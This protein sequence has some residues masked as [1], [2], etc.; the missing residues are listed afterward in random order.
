MDSSGKW[1]EPPIWMVAS[2]RSKT[3]GQV[4]C[5]AYLSKQ[6]YDNI[7]CE[8]R[9]W[10]DKFK[11]LLIYRVTSELIYDRDII[12]IHVDFH[13]KTRERICHYLKRSFRE[14]YAKH[15]PNKPLKREP[16][17]LFSST[18]H[19]DEVKEADIKAKRLRKGMPPEN[20]LR[21]FKDP[22]FE[23]EIESL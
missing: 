23:K 5:T 3:K 1:G 10:E 7:S 21:H 20:V 13:G 4:C 6:E 14:Y 2:R 11:A 12:I 18:R 22:S 17:V 8:S 15:Y 9:N 19:S 16:D